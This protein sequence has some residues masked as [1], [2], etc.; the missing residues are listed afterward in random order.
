MKYLI[1]T[2]ECCFKILTFN[3]VPKIHVSWTAVR[4]ATVAKVLDPSASLDIQ[5]LWFA[6]YQLIQGAKG[7]LEPIEMA[8]Q[9]KRK[10]KRYE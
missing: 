1:G 6:S 5:L 2:S 7:G 8:P 4:L 10:R 3:A 9:R